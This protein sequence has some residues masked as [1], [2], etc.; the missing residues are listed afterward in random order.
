MKE[1]IRVAADQFRSSNCP[2]ATGAI[3]ILSDVIGN[4]QYP[5]EQ[6]ERVWTTLRAKLA[7]LRNMEG[8]FREIIE[9]STMLA[10][11]GARGWSERLMTDPASQE[12]DPC[13]P[14]DWK[15]AWDWAAHLAYLEHIG[16]SNDLSELHRERLATEEELRNSFASSSRSGH[17]ST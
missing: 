17:S 10:E 1:K 13:I 5:P 14:A 2:L 8:A 6:I 12:G 16:A 11:A 7:S 9:T 4:P 3:Q 15:A